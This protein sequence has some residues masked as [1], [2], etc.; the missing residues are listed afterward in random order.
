MP[1]DKLRADGLVGSAAWCSGEG[2]LV[3]FPVIPHSIHTTRRPE[4]VHSS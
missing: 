3:L 1:F 2:P 4:V